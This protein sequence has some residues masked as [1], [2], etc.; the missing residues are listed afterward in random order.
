MIL[1]PWAKQR[2]RGYRHVAI[3]NL[4]CFALVA[5]KDTSARAVIGNQAWYGI[6]HHFVDSSRLCQVYAVAFP[7]AAR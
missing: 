1:F 3:E 2:F 6:V 5:S 7:W 4:F